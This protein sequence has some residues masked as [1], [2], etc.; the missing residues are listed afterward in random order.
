[1]N[2]YIYYSIH[3]PCMHPNEYLPPS[4]SHHYASICIHKPILIHRQTMHRE[5]FSLDC[6]WLSTAWLISRLHPRMTRTSRWTERM[7]HLAT[8]SYD[9]YTMTFTRFFRLRTHCHISHSSAHTHRHQAVKSAISIAANSV[10][11]DVVMI[12]DLLLG[13]CPCFRVDK[14]MLLSGLEELWWN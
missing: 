9:I 11:V 6:H 7:F 2:F 1:M 13:A 5:A 10:V 14:C 3:K 4:R 12:D 8:W